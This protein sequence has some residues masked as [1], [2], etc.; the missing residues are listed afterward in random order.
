MLTHQMRVRKMLQRRIS[1]NSLREPIPDAEMKKQLT[2]ETSFFIGDFALKSGNKD[3]A[4]RLFRQATDGCPEALL[5]YEGTKAELR[6][7]SAAP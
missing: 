2:C 6:A 3:E 4:V 1:G 5:S 7:L